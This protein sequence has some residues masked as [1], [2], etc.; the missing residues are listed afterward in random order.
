MTEG[1]FTIGPTSGDYASV[2]AA[3]AAISGAL[4]NDLTF[5]VIENYTEA[6][7]VTF[8]SID[9]NGH[10]LT[11][12]GDTPH[13]GDPDS[14]RIITWSSTSPLYDMTNPAAN[15]A[16][17]SRFVVSNLNFR[18]TGSDCRTAV[19][20]S[21]TSSPND[22]TIV[23]ADLI[24][25]YRLVVPVA[26]LSGIVI[27][28]QSPHD[29]QVYNCL[30]LDC[31]INTTG[32]AILIGSGGIVGTI[33]N[34]IVLNVSGT[35]NGYWML[36]GFTGTIRNCVGI[37]CA[38]GAWSGGQSGATGETNMADDAT[39][40]DG[41]WSTGTGNIVSITP[42]NEF[43]SVTP[44]V[45]DFL[46]PT[47]TG[48]AKDGG[49]AVTIAGNTYGA[50]LTDARPHGSY[51]S[52]GWQETP[53]SPE[54][55]TEPVSDVAATGGTITFS[56]TADYAVSYQWQD[57]DVGSNDWNDVTGETS[58]SYT[59]AALV[60]GDHGKRVRCVVT[61]YAG[62]T[63]TE[64]AHIL[65]AGESVYTEAPARPTV[66][67]LSTVDQTITI[68]VS[69]NGEIYRAELLDLS[70][71]LANSAQRSGDGDFT[72][73]V[74]ARGTNYTLTVVAGNTGSPMVW[75]LPGL[76]VGILLP[77]LALETVD[78]V[79]GLGI[80]AQASSKVI[81][82]GPLGAG[83]GFPFRFSSTTGAPTITYG[84][85]HVVDGMQQ[86][87]L[88]RVGSRPIRREFGSP[89]AGKLMRPDTA[90]DPDVAT[91]IQSAL[92]DYEHRV[93]V[94]N[95]VFKRE[96]AG[97]RLFADISFRTFMT[98]QDGNL[99]YPFTLNV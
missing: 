90:I 65:I 86:I 47:D 1:T 94:T 7:L 62:T 27:E 57:R 85:D 60:I 21:A 53:S 26:G 78:P 23:F 70:N 9:L 74:P 75:S 49:T 79:P 67:I 31:K 48:S 42:L 19:Q 13:N 81:Q 30:V 68:R 46:R 10:T 43:K 11:V 15:S 91:G 20:A 58:N 17:G 44:G 87:L 73:N 51:Y 52:I 8:G 14:G 84:V 37:N 56:V 97:G 24:A 50:R 36:S 22:I 69:G 99:V 32:G 72:I 16:A 12:T 59:T 29:F 92:A 25:D 76:S 55:L 39:V 3:V 33:E 93:E 98:H 95:L 96:R 83:L 6:G 71:T 28:A 2:A 88:T 64:T 4:T 54:I 35:G 40:A 41:T 89:I 5:Q 34:C 61:G 77:Q 38:G 66:T 80:A 82:A 63:L 45:T 18:R